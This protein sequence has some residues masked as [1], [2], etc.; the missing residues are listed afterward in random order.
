[1]SSIVANSSNI[2]ANSIINPDS[3]VYLDFNSP[4]TF[5]EFLKQTTSKLSPIQFNTLYIEYLN[6]WNEIKNAKQGN[7][8]N[9]IV[10]RYTE[11]LKEITLKYLTLDE[12]RFI[13]NIDFTD[14]LD[15]DVVLPFYSKKLIDICDFFCKKREYIKGTTEKNK[16]KGTENSVQK[17]LF[18]TITDV[19]F[20]DVV[21]AAES[22][23]YIDLEAL[24]KD[25]NIEVE[26]LFD[27]Y[28]NYLDNDPDEDSSYYDVKTEFRKKYFTSNLNRINANIFLNFS[29]AIKSQLLENLRIFLYEFG[30]NFTINFDLNSVNLN[31]KIGEPLYSLVSSNKDKAATIVQLRSDL[32]KKYIGTDFYYIITND[33]ISA[34]TYDLLFKAQNPSG[35]LLNRHFPTTA[36]IEEESEL[37]SCR[38]IG[39]FF[40]PEKNSI[41]YFSASENKYKVDTSKLQ[42]NK[43]YIFPDPN[44]YGNTTGLTRKYYGDYPLI[45]IQDY[46]STVRNQ[47][48]NQSN[49]DIKLT[50]KEQAMYPY[51]SEYQVE[52]LLTGDES[53]D[54]Y[55]SRIFDKG[56]ID[57]WTTDVYGNEY[58]LLKP[59]NKLPL[60][61]DKNPVLSSINVCIDFDGG[62]IKFDRN[63]DLPEPCWSSNPNWV[64]PNVWAS[65]YY[66]NLLIDGGFGS[67]PMGIMWHGMF[68]KLYVD[69]YSITRS[70]NPEIDF[71]FWFNPDIFDDKLNLLDGAFYNSIINYDYIINP[72]IT[73]YN[74]LIPDQVEGLFYDDNY[75]SFS[76]AV[77]GTIDG[78]PVYESDTTPNFV[79]N[80]K[81]I[82]SAY[83]LSS[84]KYVEYDGGLII[85]T[86]DKIYDFDDETNFIVR[87]RIISNFTLSSE[88]VYD[89]K[90]DKPLFGSIFTKNIVTKEIHP[91]SASLDVI[92]NKYPT[93]IKNEIYNKVIDFNVYNDFIWI[94]TL[95]YMVFDRISYNTDS[96]SD[97][98]TTLNYLNNSKFISDPFI[99]EQKDYC[100]I[101][102]LSLLNV[103][104]ISGQNIV[105]IIKKFSFNDYILIDVYNGSNQYQLFNT[106]IN[107]NFKYKFVNTPKCF[108]NTRN[109]L[110]GMLATI[111]D[112][113]G[114]PSIYKWTFKYNESDVT[115]LSCGITE[116]YDYDYIR[117]VNLHDNNSLSSVGI[118]FN[119]INS[120]TYSIDHEN[121]AIK[122]Y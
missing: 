97:S 81:Y 29:D 48:Y 73:S 117:T 70:E 47:S 102:S 19:L 54:V 32:I 53:L 44:L 25:L 2:P 61:D 30:K 39:L 110:Y 99:F 118:K 92:F 46:S 85:D 43:I 42:P 26:E 103:N 15:L 41:L 88:N 36:T 98:G 104:T 65:D 45:H 11:L 16:I 24:Y 5:F 113:N 106:G 1:V 109:N 8:E 55:F 108:Y 94:R 76:N 40:T 78:N 89:P 90:L 122:F 4:F 52:N 115:S 7:S 107:R 112:Q 18:E 82:L 35:N 58:C 14:P 51:Y 68:S 28:T 17:A 96:F 49:G 31:C 79:S 64:Y 100:L 93:I 66:Y 60:V 91:L 21:E 37:A 86:C 114:F 74:Q 95:N 9:D 63:G 56:L 22:K 62:P 84:I 67:I 119:T 80:K 121:N 111:E 13:S 59:Y 71:K 120:C 72:N 34:Y 77:A 75:N 83:M 20:V 23:Q 38:R 116:L 10:L 50:P 101:A 87:D 33:D 69:G 6:S 3:T 12:K 57:R 27:L 105:P